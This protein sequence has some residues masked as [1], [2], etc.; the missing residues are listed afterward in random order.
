MIRVGEQL[1]GYY[2]VAAI[3]ALISPENKRLGD[4]AAG[5]IV[6]RDARLAEPRSLDGN[7][8]EPAYAATAYLTAKSAR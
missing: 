4:V 7:E 3:S 1:L 5:T 6:V 2:V 8:A